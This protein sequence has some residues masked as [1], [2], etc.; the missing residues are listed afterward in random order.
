MLIKQKRGESMKLYLVQ[1]GDAVSAEVDSSRP[2]SAKGQSDVKK[3]AE[4]LRSFDLG[5]TSI[6]HSTKTRAHQTAEILSSILNPKDGLIP[7][8]GL[9]PNDPIEPLQEEIKKMESN[10][11][12]VGHLPFLSKLVSYLLVGD[13]KE[14]VT[15]RQGGIICLNSQDEWRIEWMIIPEL[16]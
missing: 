11:M 4:F 7:S 2:L 10:L 14:L 9:A 15:F 16:L 12:I 5:I 6:R 13:F 1:H 8:E 3:V